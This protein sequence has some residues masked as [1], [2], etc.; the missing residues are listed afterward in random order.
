MT[1]FAVEKRFGKKPNTDGTIL[2]YKSRIF[3]HR[4]SQLN[5]GHTKQSVCHSC[6]FWGLD[7]T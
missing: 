6:W 2:S 5:S 3:D 1:G 4:W 7:C